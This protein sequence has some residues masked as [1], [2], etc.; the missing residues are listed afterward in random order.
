MNCI[1]SSELCQFSPY[2]D[3]SN[4][5]CCDTSEPEPELCYELPECREKFDGRGKCY[6]E[7]Q[8]NMDCIKSEKLCKQLSSNA[9][10]HCCAEKIQQECKTLECPNK[11]QGGQCYPTKQDG[12]VC[13]QSE[14][15]C[16]GLSSTSDCY[17]CS[18]KLPDEPCPD[19]GCNRFFRGKGKCFLNGT[20]NSNC[21]VSDKLCCDYNKRGPCKWTNWLDRDN[22]SGNGDYENAIPPYSVP[23]SNPYGTLIG[24]GT[25][26]EFPEY[27]VRIKGSAEEYNDVNDL[28]Y[29]GFIHDRPG[30]VFCVNKENKIKCPDLEVKYKCCPPRCKCCMT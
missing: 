6:E 7:K 13:V 11:V 5:F 25:Q 29:S 21:V 28:P 8:P 26:C 14:K 20:E 4:C 22:P 24:P 30:G 10:C 2:S 27:R 9:D 1:Q 16:K 15:L 12:M 23:P 19:I 18:D 17:C 3:K